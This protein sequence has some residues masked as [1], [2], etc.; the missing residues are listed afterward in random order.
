MKCYDEAGRRNTGI[1]NL[2]ARVNGLRGAAKEKEKLIV[3]LEQAI[4]NLSEEKEK[5]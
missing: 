3:N 2:V 1:Q 4:V 5:L